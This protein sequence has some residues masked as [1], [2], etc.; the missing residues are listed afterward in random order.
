M[1]G[2]KVRREKIKLFTLMGVI[3]AVADVLVT[4]DT[5]KKLILLIEAGIR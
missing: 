2:I 4:L 1:V 5:I 3:G